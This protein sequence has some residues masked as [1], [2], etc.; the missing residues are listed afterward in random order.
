MT[1]PAP[2]ILPELRHFLRRPEVLEPTGLGR[3]SAWGSWGVIF[4]LHVGVLLLVVLPI[5]VVIQR[6]LGLS[7]PDAF[8]KIPAAW[9]LPITV[10]IAPMAEEML[11]RGWQ[12]GRPR[13]FWLLA[14]A[15]MT[16]GVL[17]ASSHG[18]APL[19]SGG[20]LVGLLIAA[21]LGWFALR[22]RPT[23]EAYRRAFP[24]I[25]WL[26]ALGFA[27]VHVMNY[28]A[29]GVLTLVLVLPQLWAGVL[30]GFSRQRFGLPASMLQHASAN[31]IV[32]A[33]AH[34]AA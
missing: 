19:V 27:A 13:A 12:T 3:A 10:L 18:L 26:V 16:A 14:C 22:R 34:F 21:P 17:T 28:A 30:L 7:P 33:L 8:G 11:F 31:A 9:L 4:A 2:T 23:P 1:R 15:L 20:L 24:T 32:M 25:Y 6:S 29:P 5:T